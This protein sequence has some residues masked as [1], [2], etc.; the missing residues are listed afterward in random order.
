M[1]RIWK[2]IVVV[3]LISVLHGGIGSRLYAQLNTDR[4]TAIG[5]NA[6]YFNDYVLSIQ[7]FNQVIKLK[8]YLAEPYLLRGIAKVQLSDYQ[9]S[10]Q[11][12]NRAIERNPFHPGAYYTRGYIYRQMQDYE[13]AERDFTSA[14]VHAPENHTY[15]L[16]R[17][18]VRAEM[19]HYEAD[20]A[21]LPPPEPRERPTMDPGLLKSRATA[22][23]AEIARRAE[24][25]H[26]D[27][28]LFGSRA[29]VSAF[30]LNPD[31]PTHPLNRGWR[32]ET[33]GEAIRPLV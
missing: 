26:V 10:L 17:A 28:A 32:R 8:P 21:P 19:G 9:G 15:K 27:P 6:L 3:I 18:D 22:L 7:Y 12:L 24:T 4:I 14:L 29:D 20:E 31:D 23:L 16:L 33:M 25:L 30:I 11:D 2:Y 13:A 5:R 1:T